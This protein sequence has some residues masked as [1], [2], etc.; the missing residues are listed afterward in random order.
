MASRQP[1]LSETR[2]ALAVAGGIVMGVVTL[3]VVSL[4]I[5]IASGDQTGAD[6]ASAEFGQPVAPEALS[7]GDCIEPGTT[8]TS[9]ATLADCGQPHSA[10]V[11]D[12]ISTPTDGTTYPGVGALELT[13]GDRCSGS[14]T[15]FIE[16]DVLATTLEAG[17]I[18][19]N[20]E[21]WA[22]GQTE[23]VCFIRQLDRSSLSESVEGRGADF[24]RGDQ[25]PVN[26]LMI[27]DCF[28]PAEG[29]G[30]YE[31][32]SN[33][34]VELQPCDQRYNGVFFGRGVLDDLPAETP[35]PGDT[36]IGRTVS[37]ACS[38]LF[39]DAF[40]VEAD[41]FNYRYWRPNEQSWD[42]GDR[43]ILCAVLDSQ[44]IEGTFQPGD[45]ERF[46]DL[47][48][49]DCFTL[50]PEETPRSLGLDDQVLVISCNDEHAGQMLGSGELAYD[51]GAPFPADEVETSAGQAC[52]QLF[53]DFIGISPYESEFGNFPF[54]YPNEPGW[55]LGDRRYACAF[56]SEEPRRGSLQDAER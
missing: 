12:R 47:E 51:A 49:G 20:S 33:S 23:I 52:E 55:D 16:V 39:R 26:R 5:A 14:A 46:F 32:N 41:G 21:Q 1:V 48:T 42:L 30:S 18:V 40:G 31:L 43:A 7:P 54:W 22:D 17:F 50:G 25:I 34:E 29:A 8:A 13:V 9:A 4:V 15:S 44:A 2:P 11:T 28:I 36:E 24:P 53:S 37:D 3:A 45:Y 38:D 6:A 27:G 19:P 56:L 10:Q 35:F